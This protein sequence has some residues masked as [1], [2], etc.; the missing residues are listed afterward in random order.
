MEEERWRRGK[1]NSCVREAAEV[2]EKQDEGWEEQG[3]GGSN[4]A[5]E[6][7]IRKQNKNTEERPG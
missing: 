1:L 5:A 6:Q 4:R 7:K 2:A 3:K